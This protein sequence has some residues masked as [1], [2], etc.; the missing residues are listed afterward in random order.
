MAR[1]AAPRDPQACH[2]ARPREPLSCLARLR[3]AVAL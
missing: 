1:E 2:P 3:R